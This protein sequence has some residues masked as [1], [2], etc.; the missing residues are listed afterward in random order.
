M[1]EAELKLTIPKMWITE[2]PKRHEVSIKIVDRRP[3]GKSG[4]RDLVEIS[5][6][7]ESLEAIL[8]ELKSDPWVR[9]FSM[10]FVESG[11]LIGEVVTHKCI[12]CSAL[13]G[14]NCYLVSASAAK[15]GSMLWRIM[16]SDRAEVQKLVG[17]LSKAKCEVSL[18]RITPISEQEVLTGRQ[19]E[20]IMI[21]FER[22]YFETPRKV[23]LKDLARITGVSQ[24]TLSEILR[25]GQKRIVVE[26]LKAKQKTI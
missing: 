8:T 14:S 15:G 19:Q 12:A 2:I 22:G 1:L 26:Y 25:K 20:V 21:A 4:V 6:T 13:I 7:Q 3:A 23:K 18:L 16:A 5:G 17:K 9:K 24:A 10:D 11:K